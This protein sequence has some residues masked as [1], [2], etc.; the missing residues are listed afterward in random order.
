MKVTNVTLNSKGK[1]V[2]VQSQALANRNNAKSR[3]T[4]TRVQQRVRNNQNNNNRGRSRSLA[5]E[6]S[7]VTSAGP[8]QTAPVSVSSVQAFP[9]GGRNKRQFRFQNSELIQSVNGS[10]AFTATKL[11]VNPGLAGT[12]PWLSAEAVKWEQYRFHFL[13]FRYVTRTATTT[14]GSVI[15]SPDYNP[16][17]VAPTTEVQATDTE[18]AVEDS[19]WKEI[20]SILNN[21][22][23]FPVGDRKLIRTGNVAGDINL[24]DVANLYLCTVEQIDTTAIGKLWVDYDVE[25][26]VPQNSPLD[27]SGPSGIFLA[28]RATQQTLTTAVATVIDLDAPTFDPLNLGADAAGVFTLPKGTYEIEFQANVADGTNEIFQGAVSIQKNSAALTPPSIQSFLVAGTASGEFMNLHVK[29]I[30]TANGTDTFRV[31]MTLTGAAGTLSMT[32]ATAYLT[33]KVA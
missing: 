17:D 11:Q 29:A 18:D 27:E 20:C 8:A 33:I 26:F 15:L 32:A 19:A 2:S 4:I 23:M 1:V 5:F 13:R 31:L 14:V 28:G 30:V 6:G 7:R 21:R 24:Y 22:S 16:R 3:R 25:F 9:L 10:V 12:F